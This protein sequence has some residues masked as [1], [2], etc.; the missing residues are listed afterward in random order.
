MNTAG[1]LFQAY[2]VLVAA[3][4]S[5]SIGAWRFLVRLV[6]TWPRPLRHLSKAQMGPCHPKAVAETRPLPPSRISR[7]VERGSRSGACSRPS[8]S[9]S[10][11]ATT[12]KQRVQFEASLT[13]I[14]FR[15]LQNSEP[16]STCSDES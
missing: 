2:A 15:Y 11:S 9:K 13:A 1:N 10:R 16:H 8:E 4:G 14:Q 6:R 7:F 5:G 12:W 3:L